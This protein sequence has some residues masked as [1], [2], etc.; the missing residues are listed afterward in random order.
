M[1]ELL[2]SSQRLAEQKVW[3]TGKLDLF[4]ALQKHHNL[5]IIDFAAE[6]PQESIF[7]E[8]KEV[9]TPVTPASVSDLVGKKLTEYKFQYLGQLSSNGTLVEVEKEIFQA[10]F[11]EQNIS[12]TSLDST[13]SLNCTWLLDFVMNAPAIQ[14]DTLRNERLI[15]RK[16]KEGFVLALSREST[17]GR[18]AEQEKFI[19]DAELKV[20]N[21]EHQ[22][23][24]CGQEVG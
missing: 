20:V 14:E 4:D 11:P 7:L 24:F 13:G 23:L 10:D 2:L 22:I 16:E 8:W 1:T 12:K 3:C 9:Q 6:L 17:D 5:K 18:H 15:W 19:F 21:W